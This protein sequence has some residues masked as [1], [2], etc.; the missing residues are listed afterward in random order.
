M[1]L[2]A[3]QNHFHSYYS[4]LHS[5][6]ILQ[7]IE[8]IAITGLGVW[9]PGTCSVGLTLPFH[10]VPLSPPSG[11]DPPQVTVQ[12]VVISGYNMA[13]SVTCSVQ[14]TANASVANLRMVWTDPQVHCMRNLVLADL[15][16]SFSYHCDIATSSMLM[17]FLPP[18]PPHL[19]GSRSQF[20]IRQY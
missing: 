18:P 1:K 14:A 17:S 3:D 7:T 5:P 13:V 11:P 8:R 19:P 15:Q 16:Q 9:L 6:I 2:R 12:S 10:L 20:I 4:T